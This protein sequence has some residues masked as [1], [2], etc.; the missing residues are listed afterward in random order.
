MKHTEEIISSYLSIFELADL[1]M[2]DEL[3]DCLNSVQ[4]GQNV[5][6]LALYQYESN[7]FAIANF[8][9]NGNV[10]LSIEQ[11]LSSFQNT[12]TIRRYA[13]LITTDNVFFAEQFLQTITSKRLNKNAAKLELDERLSLI[14][15]ALNVDLHQ[16]ES[17]LQIL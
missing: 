1:I 12:K 2:N 8:D 7:D 11:F 14:E 3:L 15:K 17:S 13:V 10:D 6:K 4:E 9:V 16:F 5:I